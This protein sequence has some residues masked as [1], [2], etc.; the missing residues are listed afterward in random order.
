[1]FRMLA[2]AAL[3]LLAACSSKTVDPTDSNQAAVYFQEGESY[4][5]SGLYQ[6]AIAS[7]EKV[8]E[9]YYSPELNTLAELKI[10]EAH[11]LAKD[12]LEASIAYEEFLK[13]HP[14]HGRTADVL[15][16]LGLAYNNQMRSPDQDQTATH[17][18]LSTFRSLQTRYPND[19][20]VEEAGLYIDYC[21]NQLATSE[22]MVAKFYLK[23]GHYAAAIIRL[24]GLLEQYPAYDNKDEAY[25]YLGQAYLKSGDR[26]RAVETFNTLRNQFTGS[27][28]IATA[29]KFVEK[30]F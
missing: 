10:A 5:E 3:L 21:L 14:N 12:Y 6:D 24:E 25:L 15:Y 11:F 17:N 16:R 1:M 27:D 13:N 9:T 30:H 4:F 29:E 23:T 7:W 26:N 28:Y 22:L 18:T 8:R 19:P 20:R 2:F